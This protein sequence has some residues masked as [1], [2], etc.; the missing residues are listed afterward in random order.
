[1][2]HANTPGGDTETVDVRKSG[3][4][5]SRREQARKRLESKRDF[6]AQIVAYFVINAFL[7]GVWAL[8]GQGYFW[9][10]W[11]MAGWGV[12]LVLDAWKVFYRRPITDEDIDR[13]LHGR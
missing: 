2:T 11:I 4:V 5:D 3:H 7:V 9:P 1:M 13:E 8:T 12:G 10:A 6:Q